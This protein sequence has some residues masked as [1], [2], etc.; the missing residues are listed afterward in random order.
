MIIGVGGKKQSGKDTVAGYIASRYGYQRQLFAEPIKS[1]LEVIFD[2]D[3]DVWDSEE[4]KVTIDPR[5]GVT[6]RE[7]AQHLGTEWGQFALSKDFPRFQETCGRNLWVKRA[8]VDI[9]SFDNVVFS[10]LRFVH[11]A[12]AVWD[13]DGIVM[14]VSGRSDHIND[15]HPSEKEIENIDPDVLIY[16]NSSLED[17]YNRVDEV[18]RLIDLDMI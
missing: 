7:M 11:E 12:Q 17:L 3:A 8:M 16:N 2:W 6:P 9:A 5:W 10:D 15:P 4:R 18:M 14:I 1:A 13:M